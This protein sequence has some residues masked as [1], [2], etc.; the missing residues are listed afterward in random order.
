MKTL[1]F[2]L[3]LLVN[4]SIIQGQTNYAG[5]PYSGTPYAVPGT[6]E[7]ENFDNGGEGV[8]YHDAPGRQNGNNVY[9][10]TDVDIQTGGSAG[11]NIGHTAADEWTK[12]TINVTQTGTYRIETY[13]TS[14]DNNGKFHLEIDDKAVSRLVNS[15][16][17]NGDWSTYRASIT[18]GVQLTEGVHTFTWYTY[19]G[20]NVDRF[21]FTR[22]GDYT[23]TSP[24][25][26]NF[27][28]PITKKM[29][30]PL[31][32]GFDSPMYSGK[33]TGVLY[34]ADPSAHVWADGRLY[35]Y[36]SHDMEPPVGCDRMDRYH[37]FSTDDM[38]NWTDHG[39]ILN[40]SQVPWGRTEGGFMWAPDCAYNPANQTYYFYFPHP[41]GTDTGSTWK[42][43]IAT[44]KE[45]A[46]NFQVQGYVE[47]LASLIDPCIFV[48]D[49]GQPYIYHGGG[50]KC[51]GGKLD[52][53]DWTKLDGQTTEMQGLH[54]FH[55]G[56]WVHKYKGKY[57][58]SH[59]D[60]QGT[61]GNQMRYAVSDSPLGPWKDMGVYIYATG[62]ETMH[63]SIVEYKN[64]WYQFYH[65]SN[66]SNH[67]A[68]RSVCVDPLEYNED[69]TL[70]VVKNWGTPYQGIIRKVVPT[71]AT[72]DIALTLEAEDFNEGGYHYAYFRKENIPEG[73]AGYRPNEGMYISKNQEDI[74]VRLRKGEWMRYTFTVEQSGIYDIDCIGFSNANN[75]RF[76]LSINGSDMTGTKNS[77]AGISRNGKII[78]KNILL[79]AGEQYLDIRAENGSFNMD[80][81][82]FRMSEPYKGTAFKGNTVPGTVQSED[83]DNG[84]QATAYY[85]STPTKN[86]GNY[87]YRN[88]GDGVGVDIENS[89]GSVHISHAHT[90]EW[91]RYTIDVTEAGMYDVS[92]YVATGLSPASLYLVFDDFNTFPTLTANTGNWNIPGILITKDVPLTKGKHVMTANFEGGI[93]TD[94]YVFTRKAPLGTDKIPFSEIKIYPNPSAGIFYLNLAQAGNIRIFDI[95]GKTVYTGKLSGAVNTV[96]LS[97]MAS[98]V[99][100]AAIESGGKTQ[101]HKLVK[102]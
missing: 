10:T 53:N 47:G 25:E 39:E 101:Y 63:G 32:V 61:D 85:D 12:Y 45:P 100:F 37:V 46:A 88:S 14:G 69:G 35:V 73:N 72:T 102:H 8:A 52:K 17:G 29:Q 49:D 87:N 23:G 92:A 55:E 5:T 70:K 26:G 60:G 56:T 91:V 24:G 68:L 62:C 3:L 42:I 94:R 84:G 90:G 79:F 41:S 76:H 78:S 38:E 66:Y 33:V 9:R 34:T 81:I 86:E 96:N 1:F 13:C 7:A 97:G 99:Y 16:D 80:K 89:H 82:Q 43:G 11:Y 64:K 75:S 93:N 71:A 27:N 28:Y 77:F 50:G 98:G 2:T 83:F 4:I 20:M 67:G 18:E 51:M 48:D 22:T 59:S 36:A 74:S 57:Y 30:N 19:G 65:T 6:V 31:F 95:N 44:S 54:A 21:V 15:Q 40:S 58:L